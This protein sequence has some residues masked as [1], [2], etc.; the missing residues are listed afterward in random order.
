MGR[1]DD[2][3]YDR[4][5][6]Q[7]RKF[8]EQDEQVFAGAGRGPTPDEAAAAERAAPVSERTRIA[9][10]EMLDRGAQQRGEGRI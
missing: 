1:D 6:D 2:P 9:Y 4:V 5:T 10:R 8:E 3:G 7:T